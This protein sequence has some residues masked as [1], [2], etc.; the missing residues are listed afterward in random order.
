MKYKDFYSHIMTEGHSVS[1]IEY[2]YDD[3]IQENPETTPTEDI[4]IVLDNMK[5]TYKE[6]EIPFSNN[7]Y[8]ITDQAVIEFDPSANKFPLT[9]HKKDR[10]LYDADFSEIESNVEETFNNDFWDSPSPLYHATQDDNVESIKEN[11]LNTTTGTGINNRGAHG[12]FTVSDVERIVLGEYGH[13]IFK[14]DTTS[15]KRDGITPYVTMEPDVLDGA[16]KGQIAHII[17]DNQ[18]SPDSSDGQ[19]EETVIINGKIDPK[20]LT[21]L[22]R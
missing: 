21:L 1:D 7:S 13:N 5:L 10:F 2:E 16:V 19:W 17:G 6:V 22:Q 18:Y 12:V 20:Y 8:I 9:F 15:M 3:Y 14:I 11:G 4:K